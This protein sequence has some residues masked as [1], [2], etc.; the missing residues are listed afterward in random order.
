MLRMAQITHTWQYKLLV[1]MVCSS[2]KHQAPDL[3]GFHLMHP[4]HRECSLGRWYY[5]VG[6]EF[7]ADA[8]YRA[9]EE[10]HRAMHATC[11]L[12]TEALNEPRDQRR[13]RRLMQQLGESSIRVSNALER[14]ESR[15]LIEEVCCKLVD[16][17]AGDGQRLVTDPLP[18][19]PR[20]A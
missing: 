4:G 9:L 1:D 14:L 11:E 15:L 6:Q 10:P 18:G 16:G 7:A 20:G 12:I 13:V 3:S 2:M 5:G 17:G 19:R 8:N